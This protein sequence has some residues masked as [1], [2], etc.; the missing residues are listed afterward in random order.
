MIENQPFVLLVLL[1]SSCRVISCLVS[2]N[3]PYDSIFA[4]CSDVNKPPLYS[5]RIRKIFAICF[6]SAN[7]RS[8]SIGRVPNMLY[9]VQQARACRPYA[10]KVD[11]EVLR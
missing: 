8:A 1:K 7:K 6:V 10:S 4:S 11:L 9:S 2:S 5:I 3:I